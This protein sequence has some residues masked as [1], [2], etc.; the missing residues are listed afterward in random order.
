LSWSTATRAASGTPWTRAPSSRVG[1]RPSTPPRRPTA[2]TAGPRP[3]ATRRP[4]PACACLPR[5]LASSGLGGSQA[6][7]FPHEPLRTPA[8]HAASQRPWQQT[9]AVTRPPARLP[10]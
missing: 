1:G 6:R 9:R 2:T 8:A 7:P 4:L 3:P 5:G 10:V